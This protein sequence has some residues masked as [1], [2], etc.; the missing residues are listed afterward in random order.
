MNENRS[1]SRGGSTE[2]WVR[3]LDH[4]A[5]TFGGDATVVE[6]VP[7]AALLRLR[8][9]LIGPAPFSLADRPVA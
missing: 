5:T 4:L 2:T 1:L 8:L 6:L 9:A 3:T 7:G